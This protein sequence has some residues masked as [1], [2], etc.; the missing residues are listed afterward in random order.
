MGFLNPRLGIVPLEGRD[1]E[2]G[3]YVKDFYSA[4]NNYGRPKNDRRGRGKRGGDDR[5]KRRGGKK[6]SG[7]SGNSQSGNRKSGKEEGKARIKD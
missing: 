3:G 6:S 5:D 2:V 7:K 4:R 1:G